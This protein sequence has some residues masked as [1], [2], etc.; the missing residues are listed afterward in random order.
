MKQPVLSAIPEYVVEVSGLGLFRP[1]KSI[2]RWPSPS[3]ASHRR[4]SLDFKGTNHAPKL[5]PFLWDGG[6]FEQLKPGF[7]WDGCPYELLKPRFASLAEFE[8]R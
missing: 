1:F 7:G 3:S 4:T 6:S 2:S 5:T 8:G